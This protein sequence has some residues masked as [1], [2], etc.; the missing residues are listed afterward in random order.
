MAGIAQKFPGA[1]FL[2]LV[3]IFSNLV[4]SESLGFSLRVIPADS[5]ESPIYRHNLT[6]LE[7]M[8]KLSDI[9]MARHQVLTLRSSHK[10]SSS[11]DDGKF[12]EPLERQA[13][14]YVAEMKIGTPF[15]RVYLVVDTSAGLVWTQC[16]PC[17]QG[18]G[19][20]PQQTPYF[21]PNSSTSYS[22]LHCNDPLCPLRKGQDP[23]FFHCVSGNCSYTYYYGFEGPS[24]GILSTDSCN[25]INDTAGYNRID[26][27][28]VFGCSTYVRN[29]DHI[30]LE[31][32]NKLSGILG[33]NLSPLSLYKQLYDKIQG[34]FSYCVVPFEENFPFFIHAHTLR[35][36]D[37]V[38]LPPSSE[39]SS[40]YYTIVKG[41]DLFYLDLVDISI[42]GL[43]LGLPAGTF[44]AKRGSGMILDS[45]TP[46]SVISTRT[47][48]NLNVYEL[49]MLALMGHYDGD[50]LV[51]VPKKSRPEKYELC[52][53]NRPGF[54]N[55]ATMTYHF[56][57][58]DY[59]V[60]AKFMNVHYAQGNFFC[61]ALIGRD[62][63]S[64]LGAFHMQDMRIVH[65][66]YSKSIHFY[67]VNCSHDHF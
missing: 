65:E 13:Y 66:G 41:D 32:G 46:V 45:S 49:V 54:T 27:A 43:S 22:R 61:I 19:C 60:D 17:D 40:T 34:K 23:K 8:E 25:F 26:L 67:P 12:V 55:W 33:L 35:F 21:E 3:I 42:A 20:Y 11:W 14:Y 10:K 1:V 63:A 38:V 37:Q 62:G 48:N 58:A 2:F 18:S 52:Y 4:A 24:M 31:E 30:F 6:H 29:L 5:Q 57:G 56:R 7:R 47:W 9:S 64:V 36:G 16:E 15:Q 59:F 51:R 50:N 28:I 39:V 53:F 44:D